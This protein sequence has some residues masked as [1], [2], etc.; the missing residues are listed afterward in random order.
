[1]HFSEDEL[2]AAIIALGVGGFL[3]ARW[4]LGALRPRP[5]VCP[6]STRMPLLAAPAIS[7][8]LL[9][10]ILLAWSSSDVRTDAFYLFMYTAMGAAWVGVALLA[11]PAMGI[12]PTSDVVDRRNAGA[13]WAVAGAVV[14]LTLSYAGGNIGDGPGWWVVVFSAGLGT[15][16]M[17]GG[18][19]ALDLVTGLS[20]LVTVE[21]DTASGVRLGGLLAAMGLIMGRS[22]AGDWHSI[23]DT[24]EDFAIIAWPALGLVALEGF[25][26]LM[27][28]PTRHNPRPSV[29]AFGAMP[30]VLYLAIAAG[31]VA[32]LG[33]W[34]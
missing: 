14:G 6:M 23:P 17:F 29:P 10:A 27:I 12:S 32:L 31:Y 19:A 22:V 26:G 18:W 28:R 5:L 20:R 7:L 8:V 24:L 3:W 13:G 21:R 1:M 11:L 15:L 9:L 16:G 33:W 25:L 34:A 4:L 2:F 30:A